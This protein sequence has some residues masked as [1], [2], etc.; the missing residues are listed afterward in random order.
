MY[1]SLLLLFLPFTALAQGG[2]FTLKGTS[3]LKWP[4]RQIHLQYA[5]GGQGMRDSVAVT[6]GQFTFSGQLTEPV[7]ASLFVYY[8]DE[9]A[10]THAPEE[11]FR[12]F[13]EPATISITTGNYL[14]ESK[15]TGNAAQDDFQ[16][17]MKKSSVYETRM[18][19]Y[20]SLL[21]SLSKAG[22]KAQV[23]KKEEEL[24][25]LEA[26]MRDKV[27]GDF[28][29]QKPGSPI[30]LYAL[31]QFTGW[32]MDPAK[33]EP[34]FKSLPE[35]TR[36]WPSALNYEKLIQAAKLTAI[37]QPALDFS[38]LDTLGKP[39]AL[40]AF[41]GKYVLI[42]FWASWCGPCRRENPNVVKAFNKYSTKNFTI[43]GVSLD[44]PNQKERWMKAIHDDGLTWS[45]VSDLKFW[46]NEVARLYGVR[47]IPQNFLIDPNG[48]IIAK[49]LN[50]EALDAKLSQLLN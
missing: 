19:D 30:A 45:H 32:E 26:E 50:G 48:I 4:V 9:S 43:L 49:N 46:D 27:Y 40:S 14:A 13:L 37:G 1:R 38:Q 23:A 28:V 2:A 31:K 21:D 35:A 33:V 24:K 16:A 18:G 7:A 34:L 29:R 44:R 11:V 8:V 20:Y 25:A 36:K 22:D 3:K 5:S 41:R 17:L 15:V 39:V 6:N 10:T 42:D 47:A 12:I